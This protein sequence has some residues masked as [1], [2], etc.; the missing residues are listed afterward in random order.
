MQNELL[1]RECT[2]TT[3]IELLKS[4]VQSLFERGWTYYGLTKE[5]VGDKM[6][7]DRATVYRMLQPGRKF[8]FQ[9]LITLAWAVQLEPYKFANLEEL[10]H[11]AY[12]RISSSRVPIGGKTEPLRRQ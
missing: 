1:D 10:Y 5:Q 7:V 4:E 2:S 3:D 8:P 9:Y 12:P 11:T 6:R